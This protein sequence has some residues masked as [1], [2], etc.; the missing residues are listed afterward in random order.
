M[1]VAL[2]NGGLRPVAVDAWAVVIL[3]LEQLEEVH[4]VARRR[5]DAEDAVGVGEH[6]PGLRHSEQLHATTR[7]HAEEVDDVE[8]EDEGV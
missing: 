5:G 6:E 1:E 7:E 2:A 3:Q 4:G 8:V